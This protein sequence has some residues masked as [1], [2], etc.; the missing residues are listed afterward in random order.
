MDVDYSFLQAVWFVLIAV[1]WIGY[2]VLEGFDFGVGMLM[3]A[4]GE[5]PGR[6]ARA[7]CTRSA[8]CGTATRSGCI[9]AGGAT[10]AAFPQWYATLFS[11]FYLAL[12]LVLVA[13]IVRGVSFEFWGKD[14]RPAL[15]HAAGSGRWSSA[16][17]SPALLWG[18]AWANIVRGVPIDAQQ[19]FTG[20]LFDL[21]NP[22]ALLGGVT[23]L[24]L[25]LSHGA[26]FLTLRTEG[27]IERARAGDRRLRARAAGRRARHRLPRLDRA[28]STTAPAS[29][30]PRAMLAA[31]AAILLATRPR[32]LA[33]RDARRASP[34]PRS[35]SCLLFVDALRRPL[36]ERDGLDARTPPST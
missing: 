8:R 27:V 31:V 19:E 20:T 10:F 6:A 21:L 14:D 23:T 26:I 33:Q 1:L 17:A 29:R 34:P 9:S 32:P 7:C 18:V 22:Y 28:R 5:D 30:S 2:F 24:S 25:F 36:P 16:A 13:L 12:F 3:R 11:G 4:V 15:A 35:R